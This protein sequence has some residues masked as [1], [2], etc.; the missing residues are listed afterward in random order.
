METKKLLER[1]QTQAQERQHQS[2]L[3]ALHYLEP[4]CDQFGSIWAP[5]DVVR[6]VEHGMKLLYQ[7]LT[8]PEPAGEQR[9][10]TAELWHLI[11]RLKNAEL[12]IW[13]DEPVY[14]FAH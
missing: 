3:E 10:N 4:F 6:G 5:F 13:R 12:G 9:V 1:L 2:A 7:V 8:E 11:L 14:L